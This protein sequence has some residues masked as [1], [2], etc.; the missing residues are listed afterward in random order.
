MRPLGTL[1][2]QPAFWDERN[3]LSD[4]CLPLSAMYAAV[5]RLHELSAAA[6][7]RAPVPVVCV[8]S[9]LVG[10]TGKTPVTLAIAERLRAR[11]P[12]L[13]VHALSRG[14]GGAS[15][16]GALRLNPREHTSE[17]VGD[18]PLLLAELSPTW[19]GARRCDTAKAA[20]AQGA[21]LLLMDDGL[22]HTTLHR[23]ISLLCLDARYLVGNG[24]VVPS[25]PLRE[26]I[27]RTAARSDAVL[28]VEPA[29]VAA[30]GRKST[31]DE[32]EDDSSGA[33]AEADER[34]R[35]TLALPAS[36]VIL[37]S[38]LEPS[39]T[40]AAALAGR[41]VLAFSGTA[42][43][44]RFFDTLRALGC[45]FPSHPLSLADHAPLSAA[46]L[47]KLREQAASHGAQLVTTSKDAARLAPSQ[48]EGVSVLPVALR[49]RAGSAE[50]LDRAIDEAL[51]A[52]E[53][54]KNEQFKQA[55]QTQRSC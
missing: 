50:W 16:A 25:G 11:R 18:E 38:A 47:E 34:L 55:T 22:Q 45:E 31:A 49:L 39:P 7:F 48:L 28:L 32:I 30:A 4:A 44:Q 35:E 26:P 51:I 17:Y 27:A 1:F 2:R 15:N 29:A 33:A 41:R 14:Y 19:I 3:V 12:G 40:V 20:C 43:P 5:T 9:S 10:G 52:C 53:S 6:S 23:D 37:R 46:L 42:R 36:M 13:S 21:D 54:R 8:G 24:R